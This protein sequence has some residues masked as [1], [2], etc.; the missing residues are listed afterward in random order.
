MITASYLPLR[1]GITNS[2]NGLWSLSPNWLSFSVCLFLL[3]L[4]RAVQG[5]LGGAFFASENATNRNMRKSKKDSNLY[6]KM[7]RNRL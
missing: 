1:H 4:H 6:D 3:N 5:M 7:V 2:A